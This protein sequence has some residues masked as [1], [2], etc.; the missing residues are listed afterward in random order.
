VV[1]PLGAGRS[2][3]DEFFREKI[4]RDIVYFTPPNEYYV[5]KKAGT[6][7]ADSSE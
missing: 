1:P 5:A 4:M 6:E 7:D 3:T 2:P